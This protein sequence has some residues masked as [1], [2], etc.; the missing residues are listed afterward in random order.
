MKSTLQYAVNPFSSEVLIYIHCKY[1][2][3]KSTDT[4]L[5][6]HE[7]AAKRVNKQHSPFRQGNALCR[8]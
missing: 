1:K 6:N 4:A 5:H 3:I 8:A 7:F 2:A